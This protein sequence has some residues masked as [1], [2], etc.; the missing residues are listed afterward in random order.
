MLATT[1]TLLAV[2]YRGGYKQG[3]RTLAFGVWWRGD[4]GSGAA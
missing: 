3:K 1:T 4:D 2:E